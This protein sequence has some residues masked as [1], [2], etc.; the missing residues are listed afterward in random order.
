M[1]KYMTVYKCICMHEYMCVCMLICIVCVYTC[2]HASMCIC[3]YIGMHVCIYMYVYICMY[4][5]SWVLSGMGEGIV[6]VGRVNCPGGEL[7]GWW[8]VRGVNCPGEMSV[9][10]M[11]AVWCL[12]RSSVIVFYGLWVSIRLALC[13]SHSKK[14]GTKCQPSF[15]LPRHVRAGGQSSPLPSHLPTDRRCTH[16]SWIGYDGVEVE[17]KSQA[18]Y[19]NSLP[20]EVLVYSMSPPAKM[21][22]T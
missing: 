1:S 16:H 10:P 21:V 4:F 14:K 7:S 13:P 2:V 11:A 12:W 19:L 9:P 20:L 15:S 3:M 17:Q 8:I 18:R 22:S 5:S 6:L